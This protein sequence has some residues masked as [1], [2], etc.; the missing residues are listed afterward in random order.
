MRDGHFA[1]IFARMKTTV[2]LDEAKLERIMAL[3]GIRTRKEAI[4][5]A[6]NEAERIAKINHALNSPL[7]VVREGEPVI[8]PDYDV[9]KMRGPVII[10]KK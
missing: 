1:R 2:D 8:D 10:R 6:L 5:F 9:R 3:M 4:A 7:Y